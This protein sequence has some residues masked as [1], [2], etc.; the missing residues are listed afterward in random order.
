VPRTHSKKRVA[1]A[2]AAAIGVTALLAPLAQTT[3]AATAAEPAY[4]GAYVR[5]LSGGDVGGQVL[6]GSFDPTTWP[7]ARPANSQ[8]TYEITEKGIGDDGKPLTVGEEWETY[9]INLDTATGYVADEPVPPGDY[10]VVSLVDAHILQLHTLLDLNEDTTVTFDTR[11]ATPVDLSVFD[12]EAEPAMT[13]AGLV[14][15]GESLGV[16][17]TYFTRGPEL[18]TFRTQYSTQSSGPE[19]PAERLSTSVGT[20][21]AAPVGDVGD[22]GDGGDGGDGGDTYYHAAYEGS[23][24]EMLN[25]FSHRV[26]ED[27]LARVALRAGSPTGGGSAGLEFFTLSHVFYEEI[28]LPHT[29]SHYFTG[30]DWITT[31]H[32]A[33]DHDGEGTLTFGDDF[34]QTWEPGK[35]YQ[36]TINVAPFAPTATGGWLYRQGDDLLVRT[37]LLADGDGF[38]GGSAATQYEGSTTLTRNGE[39][40]ATLDTPLYREQFALPEEAEPAAYE[41]T[42]TFRRDAPLSSEVTLS[43][44]FDSATTPPGEDQRQELLSM[45]EF[46][47]ELALDSTA[48]AGQRMKVP[49]TVQGAAAGQNLD[50]LS[51]EVS[52]DGGETWQ[53]TPVRGGTVCVKNPPA[54]GSVSLR[55]TATDRDGNATTLTVVDAYRTR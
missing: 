4:S 25:A 32:D 45:V 23:G 54:G 2:A 15:P 13:S 10:V 20:S 39:V 22:V 44:A 34:A 37:M 12:P 16:A 41:L 17:I 40:L 49:V 53:P 28:T 48:P 50:S 27:E 30:G 43:F 36:R 14:V 29:A 42:T 11:E 51:V 24:G 5:A 3:A 47:P 46:S 9:A 38:N 35:T 8:E 6:D 7:V 18:K 33:P 55:A 52:Y 19:V 1:A 21:W 31:L 26:S